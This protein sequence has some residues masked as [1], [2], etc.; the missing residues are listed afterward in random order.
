MRKS[1]TVRADAAGVT[2]AVEFVEAF[3]TEYGIK[4]KALLRAALTVE[5]SVGSLAAH[6]K[7][8]G[9]IEISIHSFL[10]TVTIELFS[11]GE[12]YDLAETVDMADTLKSEAS[13]DAQEMLRNIILKSSVD[14]LKYRH[15]YGVNQ[16]R[17]TIVRSKKAFL[18]QTLGA[19]ILGIVAGMVLSAVA[20]GEMNTVLNEN[21]LVPVKT[22]YM[23]ALKMIVAPVVFFSI[24]SC[25]VRFSD[26]SEL[27]RVGGRVIVLFL[28]TT[29][30][31]VAV[32]VASFLLFK[33]GQPLDAGQVVADASSITSQK[34][35]VS[36]KDMIVNVVPAN[37]LK[38]FID[39]NMLQ[40]I[41]MA[42]LCGVAA[43]LIGKYSEMVKSIF[44]AFNELFLKM[45]TLIIR[46]MPL[47]VFCSICSMM[48][49][50]GLDSIRSVL[51]IFGTFLFGLAVMTILYCLMI[52]VVGGTNPGP[53]MKK[54]APMLLQVFSMASSNA[55]IPINMEACEKMGIDKKIYSL[56]IPLGATLNMDGTCIHLAVFALALAQT[57]GVQVTEATLVAMI[58]SIVVLSMGAPGIPGSGLICLSVLLAQMNVPVEAIGLVMGI[59]ALVG[60]FRTVGNCMGDVAV[61]VVVAKKEHAL[62]AKRYNN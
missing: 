11:E 3:L 54:Y 52:L 38:A 56:S 2:E 23:N 47:A 22:M 55:S 5:E 32:G 30:V 26:L 13:S 41:F 45:T 40:L 35:D 19:M 36:I 37:F 62:D 14:D 24:V 43:G 50:M 25:I 34:M 20:P 18:Y 42:V 59:D 44:E 16:I 4:K 17:M 9:Y 8:E 53:F 10:G 46:V 6:A 7:P 60:M 1:K 27:G 33:P 51:G 21:V 49:T 48:L 28:A 12:E 61:S 15:K 39:S 57:Y 29:C 31:A 58:V